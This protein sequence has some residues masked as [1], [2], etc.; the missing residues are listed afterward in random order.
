MEPW[1][2]FR[3]PFRKTLS[4]TFGIAIGGGLIF[5]LVRGRIAAWPRAS[6]LFLWP[7]L[8]GHFVELFFLN[9][10]RPRL[11]RVRSAQIGARLTVWFASGV[12]LMIGMWLCSQGAGWLRPSR[13]WAGGPGF[14]VIELGVHLVLEMRGLGSF[15]NEWG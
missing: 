8:G 9:W 3:E 14:I 6:L 13:W 11:P 5:A 7:S 2:P 15:Y 12:V 1:K 4:R 10:L